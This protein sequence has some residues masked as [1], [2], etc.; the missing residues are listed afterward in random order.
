MEGKLQ[1]IDE[2]PCYWCCREKDTGCFIVAV[3]IMALYSLG[4]RSNFG[5]SPTII[6]Q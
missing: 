5:A 1:A 2:H 6:A 3:A 4:F